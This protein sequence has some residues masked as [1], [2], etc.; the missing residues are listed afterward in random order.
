MMSV[1]YHILAAVIAGIFT[2][3]LLMFLL[4][5]KRFPFTMI[6]SVITMLII[7]KTFGEEI[8]VIK[9]FL[10]AQIL[11]FAGYYDAKT[12]T[13]PDTVHVLII[14]TAFINLDLLQ[15]ILGFL[16]VPV[17]FLI[18]ALAKSNG[19]GGGDLK[20]MAACGFLLGIKGGFTAGIIGLLLAVITNSLY[21][22]VIS[23]DKNISFALAP[24]LGIGCFA[25]YLNLI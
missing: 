23:K 9:G 4:K 1:T 2:D 13:I 24:Y 3:I 22:K 16:I 8:Q 25:A 5:Q 6:I 15:S 7:Y 12:K 21:Y 18:P 17:S 14:L 11:I 10:F 19:V 20:L